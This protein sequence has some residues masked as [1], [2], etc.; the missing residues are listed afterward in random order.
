[1]TQPKVSGREVMIRITTGARGSLM[2]LAETPQRLESGQELR[3]WN[4]GGR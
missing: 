2:S 4:G 1:M 3:T